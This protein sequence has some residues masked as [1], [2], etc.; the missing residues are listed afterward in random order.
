MKRFLTSIFFILSVA[1]TGF[2][3][4]GWR[5]VW[6]DEFDR[7]GAPDASKWGYERGFVR[8]HEL[9][10]YTPENA[11]VV[12]GC[13]VLT[14]RPAD[15]PCPSYDPSKGNWRNRRERV[16]WTSASV[17]TKDTYSF[18]YGRLEV[19][20]RIPVVKG[21]W[22]AI[23]LLGTEYP[24][25][26]NGEIDVLEYY[27]AG[28]VP[29]VLANACWSGADE[30]N[31]IWD[32]SCTPL[33]RL[34]GGDPGWGQ[35][36]HVWR[37]DWDERFIRIYLDELLLNEIDL[38]KTINGKGGSPGVNPFHHKMYILLNLALD[39]RVKEYDLRDFPMKYEIDYVRVWERN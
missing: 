30:D 10:W 13:L 36:F 12:D 4:N 26:G 35:R 14:A 7:E 38:S 6:A 8:N 1:V 9:Q 31:P 15:F 22:P 5:L 29:S 25:P 23:W 34:S 37:M 20:A 17:I 3:Q 24:W 39:T 19:R 21:A 27:Q 33:S 16:E 32:D 11:R 28:G 18:R 2:S